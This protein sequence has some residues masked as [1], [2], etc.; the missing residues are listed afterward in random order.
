MSGEKGIDVGKATC[1]RKWKNG[2]LLMHL[3]DHHGREVW[4]SPDHVHE[5]SEVWKPNQEGKLVLLEWIAD[6]EGLV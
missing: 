5:D 3:H 1:L 4:F 6:K 2:R